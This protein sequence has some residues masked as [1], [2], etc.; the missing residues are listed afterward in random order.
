VLIVRHALG[1]ITNVLI[2]RSDSTQGKDENIN[3]K[4]L[5]YPYAYYWIFNMFAFICTYGLINS[6]VVN[7]RPTLSNCDEGNITDFLKNQFRIIS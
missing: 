5:F 6:R 7:N 1:D 4:Q 2:R 3:F